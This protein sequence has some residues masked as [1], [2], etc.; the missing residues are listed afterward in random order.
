[1]EYKIK[2]L[3]EIFISE[4]YSIDTLVNGNITECIRYIDELI[5]NG[6]FTPAHEELVKIKEQYPEKYK[7]VKNKVKFHFTQLNLNR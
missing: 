5:S 1:M 3:D 4:N 2:R 6:Y 7:Y